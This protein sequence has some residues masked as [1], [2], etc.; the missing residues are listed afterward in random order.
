MEIGRFAFSVLLDTLVDVIPNRWKVAAITI[1][2]AAA[3]LF[4]VNILVHPEHQHCIKQVGVAMRLYANDHRG[5]FPVHTNGYGDALLLLEKEY[6]PGSFGL[7]TGPGYKPEVFERA[8][9]TGSNVPEVDCGRV[10]IQGLSET[11]NPALVVLFDK[12]PNPGDHKHGLKRLWAKPVREVLLADG[13]MQIILESQWTNFCAAQ[14]KLLIED[15]FDPL[16]ATE[17]YKTHELKH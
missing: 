12:V 5:R 11:N 17:A 3:C 10:Y 16:S 6:L 8:K 14:I 9:E 1:F 4:L 7:L 15:G 2:I 13:S